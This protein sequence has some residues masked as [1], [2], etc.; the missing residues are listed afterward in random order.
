M[1][2]NLF[3]KKPKRYLIA[4][5]ML[6]FGLF[7]ETAMGQTAYVWNGS[8]SISW[9]D[10]LNWTPNGVPGGNAGDTALIDNRSIVNQPTFTGTATIAKLTVSNASGG[11]TAGAIL[12]IDSGA[13]LSVTGPGS[14]AA[15]IVNLLGGNIVNNGILTATSDGTF[16]GGANNP[17][18][19][20]Y[21]MSCGLPVQ[22]P[23]TPTEYGYTGNVGSTL[24]LN[25]STASTTGGNFSGGIIF[26]GLSAISKAE[27]DRCT[28]KMLFNGTTNFSLKTLSPTATG[29]VFAIRVSGG[30]AT[31]FPCPVI[32]GGTGFT[33]PSGLYGMMNVTGGG[34]NVTIDA[35]TTLTATSAG[36]GNLNHLITLYSFG[37]ANPFTYLTNKGTINLSGTS[38]RSGIAVTGDSQGKS[39]FDNQGTITINMSNPANNAPMVVPFNTNT[40]AIGGTANIKN[41]GSISLTNSATTAALTTGCAFIANSNAQAANVT[42]TNSGVI[43]M[44]GTNVVKGQTVTG[45]RTTISN[46]GTITS[47]WDFN[48]TTISNGAAGTIAFSGATASVSS[49]ALTSSVI[50]ATN[51]GK[52][53]TRSGTGVQNNLAGVAKYGATSVVEPGGTGYGVVDFGKDFSLLPADFAGKIVLQIGGTTAGTTYDQVTNTLLNGGFNITNATL[54]VTGIYTPGASPTTIP[55]ILANGIGT[56]TGPFASVVGLTAGWKVEYLASTVNLVYDIAYVAPTTTPVWN[57][58]TSISWTDPLNWTPNTAIPDANSD[59]TIAAGVLIPNQPTISTGA[60]IKSLTIDLGATLTVTGP[61]LI[62]KGAVA[63]NGTMTL[64]SNSNLVQI[65]NVPNTGAITV[66]RNSNA[67]SRLDY[68]LWSSPVDQDVVFDNLSTFSPATLSNRFYTYNETTNQYNDIAPTIDF[69]AATGYLIRMPDDAPTAPTTTNFAG[70]FKGVPNNGDIT[71]EVTYLD[72]THGYNAIGNPYPSTIDAQ[73]FILA[74]TT[75]IESS[76][77]FWRKINGA[78]GSAYAV[79][80]SLGSTRTA[81]S[82]LPNGTIQVGQGFFVKAKSG[83]VNVTFTNAM[84]LTNNQNQIFKTKAAQKDRVWLNLSRPASKMGTID[85]P[86]AFS[87]ALI[88]YTSDATIGVDMYD[89]KYFNDSPVALTSS[90]NEEEFTIQGRPTFDATDVVAL[91]FKNDTAGNYTIALD[92]FDGV[93]ANGQDIYLLDSKTGTETDWKKGS[94]NFTAAA[95]VDN[96]RFSLKYQKE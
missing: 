59:V 61:N 96:A 95:G 19:G 8:T 83:P 54:D 30:T 34:N 82:A 75:N 22:I 94:Y 76:L 56:I 31:T 23:A 90:I 12:T 17:Y 46:T 64:A 4:F 38:A 74:N 62:V 29:G 15:P 68:T 52:I 86:E 63:N 89:A 71:K 92:Q 39:E 80:N 41:S 77:Y 14:N 18:N 60:N 27:A 84:R 2:N 43:T 21:A 28:Y 66:N 93:F 45:T 48:L 44:I 32:I 33:L 72:A 1:K 37:A 53:Q 9:T 42:I 36:S 78:S 5:L 6:F 88:G 24:N 87:Q 70:I 65:D 25:T 73:A 49:N 79:Y 35:G 40:G 10:P 85:I 57:G 3:I 50:L 91:N 11:N 7:A 26:N 16:T 55:I 81:S 20:T 67:L 13:T 47:N 58:S 51:N 69:A